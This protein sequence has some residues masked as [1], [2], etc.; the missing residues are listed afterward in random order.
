MSKSSKKV[1]MAS[2]FIK[3]VLISASAAIGCVSNF[4]FPFLV[5]IPIEIMSFA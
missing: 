1:R 5:D 4:D 3:N 2:N